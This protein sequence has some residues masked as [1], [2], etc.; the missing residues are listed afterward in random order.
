MYYASDDEPMIYIPV[1]LL[2]VSACDCL[3][4]QLTPILFLMHSVTEQAYI[5]QSALVSI[6]LLPFIKDLHLIF[7]I[8]ELLLIIFCKSQIPCAFSGYVCGG[9]MTV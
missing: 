9:G 4:M 2:Y 8:Q 5:N 3:L 7:K 6:C 1:T